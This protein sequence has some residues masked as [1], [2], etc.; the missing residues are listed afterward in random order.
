MREYRIY[1]MKCQR[2]SNLLNVYQDGS[3]Q[4]GRPKIY[5]TCESCGR[6]R[7]APFAPKEDNMPREQQQHEKNIEELHSRAIDGAEQTSKVG[8]TCPRCGGYIRP[9]IGAGLEVE[10]SCINCGYS[11]ITLDVPH[12]FSL[13]KSKPQTK[14]SKL[15]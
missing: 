12:G 11:G 4:D 3:W 9:P 13:T 2:E 6:I 10:I 8:D 5:G 14:V 15:S 7:P 1:C